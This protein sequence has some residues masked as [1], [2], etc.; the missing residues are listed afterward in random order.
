MGREVISDRLGVLANGWYECQYREQRRVSFGGGNTQVSIVPS[1]GFAVVVMSSGA[2]SHMP[3]AV[4][5]IAS[6]MLLGEFSFSSNDWISALGDIPFPCIAGVSPQ[7]SGET[8][9]GQVSL[10]LPA[11]SYTGTYIRRDH[12]GFV[13]PPAL[14]ISTKEDGL[15]LENIGSSPS[16]NGRL[17]NLFHIGNGN[18]IIYTK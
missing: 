14:S 2:G 1:K 4:A 13:V 18:P 12:D 16:S 11:Y 3:L 5:N 8:R 17:C 7:S 6:D 10:P 15:V 9:Y